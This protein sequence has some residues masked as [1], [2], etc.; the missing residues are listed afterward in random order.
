VLNLGS[1]HEITMQSLAEEVINLFGS[2]G[3]ILYALIPEDDLQQRCP[4]TSKARH[5]LSW[6]PSIGF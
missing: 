3:E 4:D 1:Q 5:L 2:E 6:E